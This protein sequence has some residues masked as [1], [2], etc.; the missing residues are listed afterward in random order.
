M[1]D[2]LYGVFCGFLHGELASYDVRLAVVIHA[3]G[4]LKFDA[5][6]C[7]IDA[8]YAFRSKFRLF[9]QPKARYN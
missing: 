5:Q 8:I 7:K 1:A 9:P 2:W 6:K 4:A 3:L